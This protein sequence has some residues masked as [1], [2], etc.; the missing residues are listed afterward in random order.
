M[1]RIV[2]LTISVAT[3]CSAAC[4]ETITVASSKFDP[5]QVEVRPLQSSLPAS[6][7]S[8]FPWH[9]GDSSGY[10]DSSCF[11]HDSLPDVPSTP[12]FNRARPP[13]PPSGSAPG[14]AFAFCLTKPRW[15]GLI[16]CRMPHTPQI[17]PGQCVTF[18]LGTVDIKATVGD[19][20]VAASDNVA[21]CRRR[22]RVVAAAWLPCC[23]VCRDR[24]PCMKAI[25][26]A[27]FT[28][29]VFSCVRIRSGG[30]ASLTQLLTRSER[31]SFAG[32][33]G[34]HACCGGG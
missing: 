11:L 25:L 30:K 16:L 13:R 22:R 20:C 9:L 27:D 2:A 33:P 31:K 21:C 4:R 24:S 10:R 3:M 26:A 5:E 28:P 6:T 23:S 7:S 19:S 29:S 14:V 15:G 34:I 12:L 18:D 8:L 17:L 32:L 1:L